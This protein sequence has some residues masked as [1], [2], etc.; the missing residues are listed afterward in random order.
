MRCYSRA[1]REVIADNNLERLWCLDDLEDANYKI[2]IQDSIIA[3]KDTSIACR[4]S[5]ISDLSIHYAKAVSKINSQA[6]DISRIKKR[7]NIIK[8]VVLIQLL[9][10]ICLL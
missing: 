6:D 5:S 10:I 2:S 7:K 4:D 3:Y 1:Q 9:L 8:G